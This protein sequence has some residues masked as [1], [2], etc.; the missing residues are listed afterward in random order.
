MQS[1]ET[2]PTVKGTISKLLG[3]NMMEDGMRKK[4][5][6]MFIHTHTHTH[7]YTFPRSLCCIVEIATK[8]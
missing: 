2:G 3:G 7:T 5:V 4:N 8:L 1:E 6:H